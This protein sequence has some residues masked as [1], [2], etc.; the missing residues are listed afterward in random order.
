LGRLAL[1]L[2]RL[3]HLL[4]RSLTLRLLLLPLHLFLILLTRRLAN[5]LAL[6]LDICAFRRSL[7]HLLFAQILQ[8]LTRVLVAPGR[9]SRQIGYLALARLISSDIAL[10]CLR[11]SGRALIHHALIPHLQL[12]ISN[13]IVYSLDSHSLR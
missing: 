7:I 5:L 6:R 12:L 4:S 8:L 1:L 9:L 10:I 11:R 3:N 2:L 13:A